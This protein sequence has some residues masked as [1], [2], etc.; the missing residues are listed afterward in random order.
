M[1]IEKLIVFLKLVACIIEITLL[2]VKLFVMKLLFVYLK[3]Y[4][5]VDIELLLFI[6]WHVCL[7]LDSLACLKFKA[8]LIAIQLRL[9]L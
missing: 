7:Q 5:V 6:V 3:L 9:G 4:S 2:F 1:L 8:S